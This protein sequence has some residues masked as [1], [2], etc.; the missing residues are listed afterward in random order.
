MSLL[1]AGVVAVTGNNY[2]LANDTAIPGPQSGVTYNPVWL[3]TG[4]LIRT[5]ILVPGLI[6][7]TPVHATLQCRAATP[8]NIT[9]AENCWLVCAATAVA[10]RIYIYCAADGGGTD[11]RPV[12]NANYGISWCVTG[13]S[14]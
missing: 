5:V 11:G 14:P 3:N 8:Q 4:D 9:D 12:D 1:P 6:A 7:N 2:F 10:E 13:N